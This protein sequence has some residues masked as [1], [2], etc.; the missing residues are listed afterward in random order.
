MLLDWERVCELIAAEP[1]W[2]E[3]GTGHGEHALFYGHIC[4]EL[5][6]RSDGRSLGSV[7]ARGGRGAVV[8][9]TSISVSD[10]EEL[11]RAVALDGELTAGDGE[12]RRLALDEP[13]G[14]ARPVGRER[15]SR[16]ARPRFRR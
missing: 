7:L 9:S 15:R 8:V 12:L 6:R 14:L 16:G 11:T 1:P 3:P 5:V 4:G 2:W 13:A 10:R